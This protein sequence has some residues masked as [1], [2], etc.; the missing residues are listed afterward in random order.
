MNRENLKK[1]SDSKILWYG[2]STAILAALIYLADFKEFLTA[3]IR[4]DPF[5]MTLAFFFG[6]MVFLVWGYV[7]H[8]FFRKLGIETGLKKSYRL[9]MAGNFMNSITPLGQVGGEPFMAYIVSKNTDSSYEKCLSAIVSSD[10]LNAI[11]NLT[12]TIAVLVYVFIFGKVRGFYAETTALL[13]TLTIIVLGSGILLWRGNEYLESRAASLVSYLASKSDKVNQMYEATYE[14]ITTIRQTFREAGEDREHLIKTSIISHLALPTQFVNLYL[15]L[16]GV[17]VQPD[18]IGV[19]LTVLL[20]GLAIFSPTPGGTGTLEAAMSGLLI[21]FY[22]G[23][24]LETAAAAA[25]LF[26]LS[27]YW[28]GIP[29]GYAALVSLRREKS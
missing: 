13:L 17:G 29:I 25:V 26:R 4:V 27:T 21:L 16:L 28:P 2:I 18:I 20:S 12:F 10:L 9:F 11:P 24:T 3:L 7:W 8:T 23:I 22:P 15:I 14:K 6:M 5:Y 1:F 19:I